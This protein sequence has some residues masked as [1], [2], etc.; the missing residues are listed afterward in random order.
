MLLG[1]YSLAM[2]NTGIIKGTKSIDNYYC[3]LGDELP[4][5]FISMSGIG[6]DI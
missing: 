5:D 6:L 4:Q 2:T 3:E 1:G